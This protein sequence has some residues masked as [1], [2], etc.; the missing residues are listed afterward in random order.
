MLSEAIF[1]L[2]GSFATEHKKLVDLVHRLCNSLVKMHRRLYVHR[3]ALGTQYGPRTFQERCV[4]ISA[5]KN[6][7]FNPSF[8]FDL[9]TLLTSTTA[10]DRQ[11][12][13]L[14]FQVFQI[15]GN[16]QSE[17]TPHQRICVG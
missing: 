1:S 7:L 8:M 9:E 4:Q 17:L 6:I 5:L 12:M 2:P 14:G 10:A 3:Q 11:G 16:A 15:W 13:V